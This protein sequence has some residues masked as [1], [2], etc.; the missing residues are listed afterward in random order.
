MIILELMSRIKVLED[1]MATLKAKVDVLEQQS[2]E[3]KSQVVMTE[4]SV[5]NKTAPANSGYGKTT[6]AMMDACYEYGKKAHQTSYANVGEYAEL[7]VQATGMNKASAI[8]YIYAVW[9]MIEGVTY[10]RAINSKATKKYF[11]RIYQEFGASGLQNAIK[12]TRGHAAYR[13]QFGHPVDSI[14]A[15]CK[16]YEQLL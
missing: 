4:E 14:M 7:V 11:D 10:K 3:T 13:Q 6:E 5:E 15:I 8:M 9:S 2:V 1:N 12:A 16:K